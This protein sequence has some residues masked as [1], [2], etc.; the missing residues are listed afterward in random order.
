MLG[1]GMLDVVDVV[2]GPE[3][4]AALVDLAARARLPVICQKPMALDYATCQRMV[5][6][7]RDAGVPLLIHENYRWFSVEWYRADNGQS[8]DGEDVAARD[9]RELT[10]PWIGVD[11]VVRLLRKGA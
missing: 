2:T 9:S 11:V 6:A 10:T 3:T 8:Q 7:C 4:H 5:A 1:S